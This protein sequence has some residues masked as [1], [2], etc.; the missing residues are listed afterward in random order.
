MGPSGVL[1]DALP[2]VPRA[3]GA[4]IPA[5]ASWRLQWAGWRASGSDAASRRDGHE[6]WRSLRRQISLTLS[7]S[8]W[9]KRTSMQRT[10]A[11]LFDVVG[12]VEH[13][14]EDE[15]DELRGDRAFVALY[16]FAALSLLLDLNGLFTAAWTCFCVL[17]S[18]STK[19]WFLTLASPRRWA[20]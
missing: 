13:S 19:C 3:M 20:A 11:T 2:D 4:T 16:T 9:R 17:S 14:R 6:L 7:L 18:S 8:L 12:T 5:R 1:R 10:W 15:V